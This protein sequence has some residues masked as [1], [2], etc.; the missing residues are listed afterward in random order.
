MTTPSETTTT[1]TTDPATTQ[2]TA[3]APL[4]AS[5]PPVVPEPDGDS[6]RRRDPAAEAAARRHQLRETEGQRDALAVQLAAARR[7]LVET[8]LD[9]TTDLLG[10]GSNEPVL[11]NATDLWML[12]DKTADDFF[13]VDGNIDRAA[14]AEAIRTATE[15][16]PYLTREAVEN[17][18]PTDLIRELLSR[19]T[20]P[21][22][23]G[24]QAGAAWKRALSANG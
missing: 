20:R 10:D 11:Q 12:T 14:L 22:V 18:P 8:L 23:S 6:Q 2:Q 9:T 24:E 1:I 17:V 16:R 3:G 21:N 4:D 13:D 5:T 7:G 15:G 19:Q